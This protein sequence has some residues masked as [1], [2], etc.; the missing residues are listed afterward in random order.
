[1]IL[2]SNSAPNN[3]GGA[4]HSSGKLKIE[5]KGLCNH[6]CS[7]QKSEATMVDSPTAGYRFVKLCLVWVRGLVVSAGMHIP[8]KNHLNKVTHHLLDNKFGH[9]SSCHSL[10]TQSKVIGSTS[11]ILSRQRQTFSS[12]LGFSSSITLCKT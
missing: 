8:L 10:A 3:N 11:T 6:K 4:H 1:M 7:S 2:M 12:S 9:A 5:R